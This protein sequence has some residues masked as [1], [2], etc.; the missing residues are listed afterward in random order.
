LISLSPP[1]NEKRLF[2]HAIIEL[3]QGN[4]VFEIWFCISAFHGHITGS[5]QGQKCKVGAFA[6]HLAF[7]TVEAR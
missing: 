1:L 4:T 5:A 7:L 6:P 3:N 2:F